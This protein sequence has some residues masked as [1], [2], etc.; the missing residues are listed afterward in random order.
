VRKTA[1]RGSSGQLQVGAGTGS[2]SAAVPALAAGPDM[3]TE[4][5]A[6]GDRARSNAARQVGN[7]T[8]P[9]CR[10]RTSAGTAH[11]GYVD[12]PPSRLRASGKALN[13]PEAV[14]VACQPARESCP[15]F[16]PRRPGKLSRIPA[17][18]PGETVP[19]SC[20]AGR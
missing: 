11:E 1:G 17:P 7:F 8:T 10:G 4:A 12:K 5:G 9:D 16:L 6:V 19:V 3:G 14:P 2:A 18:R 15:E 20:P 13:Q